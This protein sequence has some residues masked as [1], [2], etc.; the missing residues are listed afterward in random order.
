MPRPAHR[1]DAPV[2]GTAPRARFSLGPLPWKVAVTWSPTSTRWPWFSSQVPINTGRLCSAECVCSPTH[3]VSE[4]GHRVSVAPE[5]YDEERGPPRLPG[6]PVRACRGR[7][8]RRIGACPRP[9]HGQT[10]VAFEQNCTLGI[11][12]DIDFEAAY[13]TAHALACLRFAGAVTA[14]VA[15]LATGSGGLTLGRA[16]FTPAG[17]RTK[18][19][20]DIAS[21]FSLRP[22]VPG[23]TLVPTH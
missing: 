13:P 3:P 23:R 10:L 11:R 20:G 17:R 19:H 1:S 6:R 4:S 7:T 16:G 12:D 22:A 21:S 18:F 9:V 5:S 15:R 2:R 14:T 8:P